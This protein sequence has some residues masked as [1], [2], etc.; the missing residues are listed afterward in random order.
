MSNCCLKPAPCTGNDPL[1]MNS[2]KK[3]AVANVQRYG[4]PSTRALF[5]SGSSG[6][7]PQGGLTVELF[8]Q[9]SIRDCRS[10]ILASALSTTT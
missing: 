8:P 1:R 3:F 10:G 4:P 6:S 9:C 7:T 2:L 5:A